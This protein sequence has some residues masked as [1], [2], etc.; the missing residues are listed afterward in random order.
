MSVF[1]GPI[2]DVCLGIYDG[3]HAT[4]TESD[5]GPIFL[6]IKN[7]THDGR[8]DF[9]EIRHVSEQEFPRWTRR[10]VPTK[11]DIVFSYEATLHL[12][13]LIPE[14]F[15]G[16]LGRRMALV[17]PD[18]SKIVSQYLHYYF[19]SPAW[20]AVITSNVITGATVNRIPLARFP[21]F[22]VRI[23][24]FKEQVRI[25]DIL[26]AYDDF[27]ENNRR[28]IA[29]LEQSAR[30]LYREWFVHLRY[31]G[32]EHANVL[33]G[34][35]EG[36]EQ[37]TIADMFDTTSG[38]T[39]SRANPEFFDGD[40]NW[41]KTQELDELFIFDTGEHI[42]E[43]ALKSSAAKLFPAGTLLVSIYGGTNIGRTGLLA[44]A[45]A[46][47]QACVALMPKRKPA[48]VLFAQKWLQENRQYV[49]GLGQG[50][51]QTNINQQTLRNQKLLVPPYALLDEFTDY[52]KPTYEQIANLCQQVAGL[53]EAR[54]LLLPR[55]MSGEIEV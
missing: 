31:P 50:A 14:G 29:L 9:S 35:P 7:V 49:V 46:S 47:N 52:I 25:A 41:V 2:K 19:L 3:P 1:N 51:A 44:K 37:K 4:P 6:G 23:P 38:G 36:W 40:I 20:K 32:H 54:D 13:A 55:L 34:V 15:V 43:A 53:K 21:E 33:N 10:V 17:R 16:C 8:L 11:G 28:R 42:S 30:L 45:S 27:I 26:S 5:D 12:Y 22:P 48:D 39:P 18:P 24:R